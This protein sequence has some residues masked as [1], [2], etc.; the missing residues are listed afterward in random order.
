M[1]KTI[2]FL[3]LLSS[4]LLSCVDDYTEFNDP[5]RL[6]APTLKISATGSNAVVEST[7]V[8]NWQKAYQ[9]YVTYDGV[10][11]FTVSVIDAPGKVGNILVENSVPEFGTVTLDQAS[12]EALKGKEQGQFSFTF[13]PN[14][15]LTDKDKVERPLNFV[16][17]VSDMQIDKRGADNPKVT[18]L[19]IPTVIAGPCLSTGILT[20]NY[21]VTSASGN[22]DG[23]EAFT[24]ESLVGDAGSNIVV[25]VMKD[26]PGVYT[27]HEV[28]AG[29]WPTYYSGRATPALKVDLCGSGI[30]GREGATVTGAGTVAARTFTIDGQVNNDGTITISWSYVRNDGST[31]ASPAKGTYTLKHFSAL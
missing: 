8:N 10:S 18:T 1:N 5:P 6:D 22:L 20:G 19:T 2:F 24:L 28:T 30:S 11:N 31:P 7:M 3:A 17:T 25:S 12:V 23:G 27:I 15:D 26:R 16:I 9:T 4:V 14:P 21:L 29:V 13:T